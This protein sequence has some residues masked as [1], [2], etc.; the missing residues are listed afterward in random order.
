[1]TDHTL[2]AAPVV[3]HVYHHH[4]VAKSNGVAVLLEL[5][6]GL[7]LQTFGIGHLYAGRTGL[8]LLFMFGYWAVTF[9]NVLLCF[10]VIGLFTWPLCWIITALVTT[11]IAANSAPQTTAV[12]V[13]HR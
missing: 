13:T 11:I 2:P 1:M 8:G 4:V 3:Q 9:V 5:L 6:P 10:V 7:L 12:H